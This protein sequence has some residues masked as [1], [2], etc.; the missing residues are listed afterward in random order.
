MQLIRRITIA[1]AAAALGAA[2]FGVGTASA[3]DDGDGG[4]QTGPPPDLHCPDH[5][6]HP[7]KVE[8]AEGAGGL[9]LD[10]GTVF[11]AKKGTGHTGTQTADGDTTLYDY[12]VAAGID[13]AQ[14]EGPSY[15]IV[16]STPTVDP[17]PRVF[18][19]PTFIC[20]ARHDGPSA[21]VPGDLVDGRYYFRVG[22]AGDAGE[23]VGVAD[24]AF[25]AGVGG[26]G[27]FDG[28]IGPGDEL[29]FSVDAPV[30]G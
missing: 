27:L 11:C 4:T 17:E 1:A 18:V 9:V 24:T 12:L 6:G 14:G 13:G 28:T 2:G 30:A 21:S 22:R 10:D 26:S 19:R 7:G 29:F 23:W 15:Y 8:S 5:N 20:V 3:E 25:T 16:Y